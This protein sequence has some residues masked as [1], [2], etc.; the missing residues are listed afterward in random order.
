[1]PFDAKK[2][3]V[4]AQDLEKIDYSDIVEAAIE[5]LQSSTHLEL[6]KPR[7]QF[8]RAI[9]DHEKPIREK[10]VACIM[11]MILAFV[12]LYKACM[13]GKRYANFQQE[14]MVSINEYFKVLEEASGP[15]DKTATPSMCTDK[16]EQHK[17]WHKVTFSASEVG[18][19][20]DI[21]QQRIVFS[22][23]S[24]AVYD[25]MVDKVKDYKVAEFKA[26]GPSTRR[27]SSD[28]STITL[29]RK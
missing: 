29:K 13:V 20:L 19:T 12:D 2:R 14:W 4:L 27:A 17:L 28:E 1:M 5:Q 8:V 25:L 3:R 26:S 22:T 6:S 16:Q 23:L 9:C 11:S 21:R 24:Y 10:L 7:T 15:Q 18:Y